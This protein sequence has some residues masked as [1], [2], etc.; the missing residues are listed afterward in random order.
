M[1]AFSYSAYDFID[2]VFKKLL[3]HI[4][5]FFSLKILDQMF[6][7]KERSYHVSNIQKYEPWPPKLP[8][9]P[10]EGTVWTNV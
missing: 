4:L 1:A 7:Y 10:V 3:N 2:H 5:I 8:S 9:N 6:A